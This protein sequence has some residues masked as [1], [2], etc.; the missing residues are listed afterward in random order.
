MSRILKRN[1]GPVAA[2]V[3]LAS[4]TH[5]A[6]SARGAAT[7]YV[8]ATGKGTT[9]SKGSPC[10]MTE[11]LSNA[12]RV[13]AGDTIWVRGGIYKPG[14][15]N[16]VFRPDGW[17]GTANSRI[18]M[19][20]YNNEHVVI[21]CNADLRAQGAAKCFG[22]SN[23]W[24]DYVDIWGFDVTNSSA[25]ARTQ[26]DPGS[27]VCTHNEQC[28]DGFAISSRGGRLINSFSRNNENGQSNSSSWAS[29]TTVYGNMFYYNGL[30]ATDRSHGH[31]NYYQNKIGPCDAGK[32]VAMDNIG[33]RSF[34]M[35]IHSYTAGGEIGCI[36]Y[37][38][39]VEF[40]N[41]HA[42]CPNDGAG[43][44]A[45]PTPYAWPPAGNVEQMWYGANG[46][47]VKDCT[48][49]GKLAYHGILNG[50]MTYSLS[51]AAFRVGG[52]KGSCGFTVTNNYFASPVIGS[53]QPP[54]GTFPTLTIT[55]NTFFQATGDGT[56][57]PSPGFTSANYPTNTWL[58]GKPAS[59]KKI[60]YRPNQFETGRGFA[61]VY[62]WDH[63]SNVTID[64]AQ[65]GSYPNEAYRIFNAQDP[66]PW[67]GTPIATGTCSGACGTISVPAAAPT[68][69]VI[70]G[71]TSVVPTPPDVGPEFVV[72]VMYPDWGTA[73]P[74][75]AARPPKTNTPALTPSQ[76][77]R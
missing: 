31:S 24:G 69:E 60:F 17:S 13:H 4:V 40:A 16:G 35:G 63:S 30:V 45:G 65:M 23:T 34:D 14:G 74:A 8:S 50:N 22:L 42:A 66:N 7:W 18:V 53:F 10:S 11:I 59:G 47:A 15:A 1:W 33:F 64:L 20:N 58:D 56:G 3:L 73:Q 9:C 21:D 77:P 70:G 6:A 75:G 52:S 12:G 76:T 27:N 29:A 61:V 37:E 67:T 19:R 44:C 25:F 48:Q 41:G 62:N 72:Y 38:Y 54:G 39:N 28:N 49:T 5:W 57:S 32:A 46:S 43:H 51:G 68:I 36:D 55:G 26:T 2:L 71:D